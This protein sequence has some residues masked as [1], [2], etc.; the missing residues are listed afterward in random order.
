[1]ISDLLRDLPEMTEI[2]THIDAINVLIGKMEKRMR[3]PPET[4]Q[5]VEVTAE[6]DWLRVAAPEHGV[7]ETRGG[8][9]P[10][11]LEY[12]AA[13]WLNASEDEVPWCAAFVC[14]CL[15]QAGCLNPRTPRARDFLTYGT[16][17]DAPSRGCIAVLKRG[18]S[19][20]TGHV[21]FVLD[22]IGNQVVL[23]GGNQ[24]DS[25]R[26]STYP[27]DDVLGWR[28][29]VPVGGDTPPPEE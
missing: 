23:L 13:T 10:R 16:A 17:L 28:W 22:V 12:H 18:T 1:M 26:V 4:L 6:L 27:V 2:R 9:T 24:S 29:P 19:A 11:I 14:W 8:E 21:G 20:T 5:G 15:D 7:H 3:L 25:V